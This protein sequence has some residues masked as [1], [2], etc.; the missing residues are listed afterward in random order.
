MMGEGRHPGRHMIE[1]AIKN[2]VSHNLL[3][4]IVIYGEGGNA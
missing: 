4:G 3:P 2:A 1:G